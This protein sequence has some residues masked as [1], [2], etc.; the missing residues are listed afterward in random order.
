VLLY[1]VLATNFPPLQAGVYL[2]P[3]SSRLDN[4]L[5]FSPLHIVWLGA[6]AVWLFFVLSGFVLTKAATRPNFS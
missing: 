3:A 1:H 6:E 5:I 2:T 4:V